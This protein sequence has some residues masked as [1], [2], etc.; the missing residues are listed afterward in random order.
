MSSS[1]PSFNENGVLGHRPVCHPPSSNTVTK[2]KFYSQQNLSVPTPARQGPNI[3]NQHLPQHE[4][5]CSMKFR[6]IIRS[7]GTD[8]LVCS[9]HQNANIPIPQQHAHNHCTNNTTSIGV[10]YRCRI[11][12]CPKNS[13]PLR[14]KWKNLCFK[15][16]YPGAV[17][18]E[19]EN[20]SGRQS[21]AKTCPISMQR[22][23]ILLA[24]LF[25]ESPEICNKLA[26][27]GSRFQS[28]AEF[29]MW[30]PLRRYHQTVTN[31]MWM[32]TQ[33]EENNL[34]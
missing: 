12:N 32:L 15:C 9:W 24:L 19:E 5:E 8:C 31:G 34:V 3:G 28:A 22:A 11:R 14:D 4:R 29:R 26:A 20:G 7:K 6:S 27:T 17:H 25:E 13:C 1:A 33:L 18:P 10:C 21:F 30:L 16:G 23:S 2:M